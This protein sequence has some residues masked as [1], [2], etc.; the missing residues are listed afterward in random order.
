MFW[1]YYEMVLIIYKKLIKDKKN[2]K[3]FYNMIRICLRFKIKCFYY[4]CRWE[5]GG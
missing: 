4:I 1:K 2:W 5:F 3:Y